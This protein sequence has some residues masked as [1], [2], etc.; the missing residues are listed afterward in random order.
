M[1]CCWFA[2][3]A[4]SPASSGRREREKSSASVPSK[5]LRPFLTVRSNLGSWNPSV[6]FTSTPPMVSTMSVK[7]SKPATNT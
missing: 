3:R 5:S 6:D 2:D 1:T 7:P 4:K